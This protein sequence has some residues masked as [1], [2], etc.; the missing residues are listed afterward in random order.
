MQNG[1]VYNNVV[2]LNNQV[3]FLLRRQQSSETNKLLT[4]KTR[5][6]GLQIICKSISNIKSSFVTKWEYYLTRLSLFE[7]HSFS[8]FYYRIYMEQV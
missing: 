2:I 5:K 3:L 4:L 6:Y 1:M 8:A 7:M